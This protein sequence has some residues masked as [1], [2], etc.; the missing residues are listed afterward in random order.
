M[1]VKPISEYCL[2]SDC[3]AHYIGSWLLNQYISAIL[4]IVSGQKCLTK[5]LVKRKHNGG[6][7]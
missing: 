6:L 4:N 2:L 1:K 5:L 3:S 7:P